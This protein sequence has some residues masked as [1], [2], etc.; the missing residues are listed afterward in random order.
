MVFV[1]RFSCT[2]FLLCFWFAICDAF[3]FSLTNALALS[4]LRTVVF[5]SYLNIILLFSIQISISLEFLCFVLEM[6]ATFFLFLI[7][8][9]NK[10]SVIWRTS[11]TRLVSI[12]Y[13]I[14][15]FFPYISL[16]L[17]LLYFDLK[18]LFNFC[19]YKSMTN[20]SINQI[21]L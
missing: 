5:F 7:S 11:S 15:L 3:V 16:V 17:S 12:S 21:L 2:S 20:S 19:C 4:P 10:D 1:I 6:N 13:S 18:V 14:L 9:L 8:K